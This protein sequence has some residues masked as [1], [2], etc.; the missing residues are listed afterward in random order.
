MSSKSGFIAG[1]SKSTKITVCSCIG[2]VLLTSIILIFFVLFPITPSEKI[3][4]S[5]GRENV[6]NGG[7]GGSPQSITP[8]VVTTVAGDETESTEAATEKPVTTT[9]RTVNIR[10]TTGSGFLWNGRIPTGVM[11]GESYPTT[12]VE[13]PVTPTPD[14][15]YQGGGEYPGVGE[16]PVTT[17]PIDPGVDVPPATTPVDPGVDVPPVTTPPIDPGVDVPPVVNPE[18]PAEEPITPNENN[19]ESSEPSPDPSV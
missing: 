14:P 19:G 6:I 3:M 2:F 10:I 8:G 9:A 1:L 17:P 16:P 7:Q 11:P 4:A 5:I 12:V 18:P 15:G 13:D